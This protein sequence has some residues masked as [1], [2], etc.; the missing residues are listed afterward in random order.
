MAKEKNTLKEFLDSE[1][2]SELIRHYYKRLRIPGAVKYAR[3]MK[4]LFSRIFGEG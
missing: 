4:K 1:I 2:Y 3:E